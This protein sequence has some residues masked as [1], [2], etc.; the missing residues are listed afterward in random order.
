MFCF[1]GANRRFSGKRSSDEDIL[2]SGEALSSRSKAGDQTQEAVGL[3]EGQDLY[4]THGCGLLLVDEVWGWLF[5]PC[6]PPA[7]Y[8]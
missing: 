2:A 3:A 4:P 5:R 6:L 1:T 8:F 7:S